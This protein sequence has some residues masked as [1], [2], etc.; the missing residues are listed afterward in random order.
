[1]KLF[2]ITPKPLSI[3]DV[4]ARLAS[5]A[6]GAVGTFVGVVRGETDGHKTE[7]LE[8]EAYPDMAEKQLSQIGDEI[9]G[10]WPTI[11]EVAIVHRIGRLE[12]GETIVVIAVSSAHRQEVFAA[13]H[14]AI[15]RLKQI[16]PVWKKEVWTDGEEWRSEQRNKQEGDIE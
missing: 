9:Q 5:P 15:D 11:R 8:Y 2:E 12:I 13:T 14:Y 4:V 3:D 7:Y 6:N 16:V 1:M 10:R